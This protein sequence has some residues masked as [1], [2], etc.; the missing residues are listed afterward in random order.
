MVRMTMLGAAI[1]LL[2]CLAVTALCWRMF[3]SGRR[4]KP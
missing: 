4:L 1:C 3:K 2:A